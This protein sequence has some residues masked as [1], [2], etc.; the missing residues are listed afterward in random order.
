MAMIEPNVL[1]CRKCKTEKPF[2]KFCLN[3]NYKDGINRI[4][5]LCVRT[6]EQ[7]NKDK[8]RIQKQIYRK[9]NFKELTTEQKSNKKE[10]EKKYYLENRDQYIRRAKVNKKNYRNEIRNF[11]SNYFL[12]HPCMDCGEKDLRVLDFDHMANKKYTVAHMIV[13]GRPLECIKEEI[14]KCVVRCANCH[15][16][17]T[18]D[19]LGW[20]RSK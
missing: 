13:S 17:K 8:I 18:S 15:R 10:Y 14:E 16:K 20:W 1:V 12:E 7:Q 9:N 3:K 6:Y 5:R 19:Q 4:C 2:Q 11:I